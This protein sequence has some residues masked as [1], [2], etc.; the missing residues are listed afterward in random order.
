MHSGFFPVAAIRGKTHERVGPGQIVIRPLDLRRFMDDSQLD[1]YFAWVSDSM[2]QPDFGRILAFVLDRAVGEVVHG[3][4]DEL[5]T[6]QDHEIPRYGEN[7]PELVIW[8]IGVI[9]EAW[10]LEIARRKVTDGHCYIHPKPCAQSQVFHERLFE[11]IVR[12]FERVLELTRRR[13]HPKGTG[14]AGHQNRS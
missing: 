3:V 14:G 7:S 8:K 1:R 5:K 12:E 9:C 11:R 2:T 6:F 10:A 13:P 4:P